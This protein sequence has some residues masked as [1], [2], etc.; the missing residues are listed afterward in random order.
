M[1]RYANIG[2]RLS[3]Q[4]CASSSCAASRSRVATLWSYRPVTVVRLSRRTFVIACNSCTVACRAEQGTPAEV[5]FHKVMKYEAGKY[6]NA[7]MQFLPMPCMHCQ[8]PPCQ[9]VC[10]TGAIAWVP[11]E[12]A[13]LPPTPL[14]REALEVNP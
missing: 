10:P 2:G 1:E 3:N 6:P 7:K 14:D 13:A 9:K 12:E 4:G 5:H 8:D 11:A